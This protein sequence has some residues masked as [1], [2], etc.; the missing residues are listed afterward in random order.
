MP[1][2]LKNQAK[3]NKPKPKQTPDDDI[4]L[5]CDDR[6]AFTPPALDGQNQTFFFAPISY[7]DKKRYQRTLDQ[8]NYKQ[9]SIADRWRRCRLI[10]DALPAN[11]ENIE[12]INQVLGGVKAWIEEYM[13]YTVRK[14]LQDA[15]KAED[16]PMMAPDIQRDWETLLFGY[17]QQDPM[18]ASMTDKNSEFEELAYPLAL[19]H[20]RPSWEGVD[21]DRETTDIG[22]L[23]DTCVGALA[24][25]IGD[26]AFEELCQFSVQHLRMSAVT[27][28]KSK[29]PATSS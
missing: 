12:R 2:P 22:A 3:R 1:H 23:S 29:S 17:E 28:K 13:Q 20:A 19:Q 27:E 15:L 18:L 16:V 10:A 21:V 24:Q 7:F 4:A 9:F 5:T 14:G 8:N 6:K 26:Y 11:A 25:A